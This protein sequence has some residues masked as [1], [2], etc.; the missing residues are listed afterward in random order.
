MNIKSWIVFIINLLVVFVVVFLSF[1]FYKEFSRVIDDRVL[2][3]LNSIKTL[4]QI[5]FEKLINL[6]WEKFNNENTSES[7]DFK[8]P[9]DNYSSG[10]IF[11]VTHLHPQKQTSIIFIKIINGERVVKLLNY[12]MIKNILLERTGMG[13]TGES[14][15]V[16]NDFRLRSQSRFYPQKTPYKIIAKT[17]GVLYGVKNKQGTGVFQDY[18]NTPVY[19]AYQPIKIGNLNW[20]ILSEID[21]EEVTTPLIEMRKKLI[22]ITFFIII[23]SVV[24]SLFLTRIITN[25]IIK[26]KEKLIVMAKGNY[27][28]ENKIAQSEYTFLNL[29][30]EIN[31]MFE[32][33]N[34]LKIAL[35]GAVEFT[36]DIGNMNLNSSYLPKS[37]DDLL[38]HTLLKMRKNLID[39]RNKEQQINLTNKRF[40][41]ERLEDERRKLARELHDGIGPFLTSLK[42]YV[43]NH[44][45][46]DAHKQEIKK[47]IDATITEVRSMTNALMPSILTDFGIGA[48]L[49]NYIESIQQSVKIL[50]NFDDSSKSKESKISDKQAVNLFRITQELINNSIKHS[51]A[52]KI[53]ITLSEFNDF[54]SLYY[55]DNG[56]G[57]DLKTVK[58]GSGITNIKERV[59]IFNGKI[60]IDTIKGNTIFEIELP[61]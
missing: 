19:S 34:S 8:L 59:E 49:R 7:L 54:I 61:L 48:A 26:M 9:K 12:T 42:F 35:S 43:Q 47:M 31:E 52:S 32:A 6:E 53:I 5:Q 14:Y 24:I 13:L 56:G 46:D 33:L 39:F 40:L 37:S 60:D 21:V 15:L 4:K 1:T 3:Q 57:F 44:I 58:L 29:P 23:I 28:E 25:P 51:N 41:V 55:Y 18:R 10:G 11:D 17:K 2:L 38:G 16:G 36:V 27:T 30:K 20:V 22:L 45:Y 50:I